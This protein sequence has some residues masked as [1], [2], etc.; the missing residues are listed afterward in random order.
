MFKTLIVGFAAMFTTFGAVA[1]SAQSQEIATHGPWHVIRN[2]E[3]RM[4]GMVML[5]QDEGMIGVG[6]SISGDQVS[7]AL[8]YA[9]ASLPD[10]TG[11]T[12]QATVTI[13]DQSFPAQAE[14]MDQGFIIASN[15][16]EL[17]PVLAGAQTY[18]VSGGG[19]VIYT[20]ESNT[21]FEQAA[22]ALAACAAGLPV[23]GE[24]TA[25]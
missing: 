17:L 11:Q 24:T 1:A 12:G 16:P 18:S 7:T 8:V 20:V 14:G 6:L 22:L 2:T 4:C 19:Q 15:S 5:T 21:D 23:E 25:R 10:L 3:E 9:H 13:D